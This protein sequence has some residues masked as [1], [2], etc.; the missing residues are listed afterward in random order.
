[1]TESIIIFH[2]L[3]TSHKRLG[4]NLDAIPDHRTHDF[5]PAGIGLALFR[6]LF[7]AVLYI[8]VFGTTPVVNVGFKLPVT[9]VMLPPR[10][11]LII[12]V[13]P[14]IIL[15]IPHF[16]FFRPCHLIC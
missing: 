1:M 15:L 7:N 14:S 8:P 2:L 6:L 9:H 4:V 13:S 3:H 5:T 11:L 10:A 12:T 16:D